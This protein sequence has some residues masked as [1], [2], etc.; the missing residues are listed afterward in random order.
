M[1]RNLTMTGQ[2]NSGK[3]FREEI[4][5]SLIESRETILNG[6]VNC[7]PLPFTR[8]R[9]DFPG[10]RKKFYYLISGATKSSKTQITNFLFIITP[11]FYYIKHPEQIKPKIFYF[12]L[13]ETK[14]DITLRFYSYVLYYI[15]NGR[16]II[17]PEDLESV[18]E[19]KPLPQEVL[20]LMDSEE[21]INITNVFEEC[22]EFHESQKNPTGIYKTVKSYLDSNGTME[23]ESKEITYTDDFGT[24]KKEIIRKAVKYTPN[25]PNEYV[26]FITDHAGLLQEEKG[27]TKKETIE[28]LSEYNMYLRN[29]YSA[30][31]VLVQQQNSKIKICIYQIFYISLYNN[32]IKVYKNLWKVKF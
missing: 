20:D 10:I 24:T 1:E 21:F 12:P 13:E 27:M 32:N 8:F 9:E 25:N 15:T 7:I 11:L 28:K 3:S 14:E 26:I 29:N 6:G 16:L 2:Q 17:S 22:V 31:P 5:Q 18:D 19:R 4:K 30:I 23:Y